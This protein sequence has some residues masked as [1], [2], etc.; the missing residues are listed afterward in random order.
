MLVA[1]SPGLFTF[2]VLEVMAILS[3]YKP[4]SHRHEDNSE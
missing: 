3:S 1:G 2:A 4:P